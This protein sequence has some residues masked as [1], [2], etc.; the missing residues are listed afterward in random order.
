VFCISD[1]LLGDAIEPGDIMRL[2]LTT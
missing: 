1:S 2:S